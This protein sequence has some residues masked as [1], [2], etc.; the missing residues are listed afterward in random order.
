MKLDG[1]ILF[2]VTKCLIERD[3]ESARRIAIKHIG[4]DSNG[5]L[6]L[7]PSPET[8][9]FVSVAIKTGISFIASIF[10]LLIGLSLLSVSNSSKAEFIKYQSKLLESE[11]DLSGIAIQ[12]DRIR[13]DI[14]LMFFFLILMTFN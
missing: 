11:F 12:N 7:L 5:K 2:K 10:L 4:N 6:L 9:K 13:L 1:I 3:T 14:L 8:D